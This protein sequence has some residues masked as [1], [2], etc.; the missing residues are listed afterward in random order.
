MHKSNPSVNDLLGKVSA[1]SD[2]STRHVRN[3]YLES[4][5][6]LPNAYFR[7]VVPRIA[8][9]ALLDCRY[10]GFYRYIFHPHDV[11]TSECGFC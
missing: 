8:P 3:R 5:S 9:N 2:M 10:R 6:V 1:S 4:T 7:M 11:G